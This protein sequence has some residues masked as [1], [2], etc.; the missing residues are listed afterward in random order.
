MTKDTI[1]GFLRHALT[2][3]GGWLVSLNVL[4]EADVTTAV[5]ALISLIGLGW[6]AW[7]KKRKATS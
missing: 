4:E 2:F 6:S 3:A 1:L 7:D 5:G